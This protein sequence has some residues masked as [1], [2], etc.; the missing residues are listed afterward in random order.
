[1]LLTS[2][3]PQGDDQQMERD[4]ERDNDDVPEVVIQVTS[5][6]EAGDIL[7]CPERCAELIWL[8][9]IG[10]PEDELP[11][12]YHNIS[13]K[14]RLLFGDTLDAETGPQEVDVQALLEIAQNLRSSKGK[15]LIHCEA[16]ISR[17]TAAALILYAC[18]LGPGREDEAMDL[19]LTQRPIAIP[20]R[21]M[22]ELADSLLKRDGRLVEALFY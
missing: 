10:A 7:S 20:N 16:G 8:I 6:L 21:R 2:S 18:W 11:I 3:F 19:V 13:T 4:H 12:G 22:V 17:S 9:S 5:R 14:V 1:V 15:V